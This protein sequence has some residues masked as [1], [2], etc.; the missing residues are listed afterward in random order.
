MGKNIVSDEKKFE[1][2]GLSRDKKN[3][4]SQIAK[5][6]GVSKTCVANTLKKRQVRSRTG[7][8][9]GDPESYR[10]VTTVS[11]RELFQN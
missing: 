4:Y 11:F 9:Q 3:S 7:Q 1:I 5:L 6:V 8:G 2:V 10:S